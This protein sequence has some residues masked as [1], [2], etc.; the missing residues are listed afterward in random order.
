MRNA[1]VVRDWLS[2]AMP[3]NAQVLSKHLLAVST[4]LDK[5]AAF[6][7]PSVNVFGFWDWVGGRYSVCSAAGILPLSLH[8]GHAISTAFLAGA[9]DMDKHFFEAPLRGNLP[10]LLGLLGIWNSSFL[11]HPARAILPYAQALS[12]FPA[13]IQQLDMESNGK[14]VSVDGSVLGFDCGEIVFGEPG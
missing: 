8:F 10:V 1:H 5:A 4:A 7:I 12:R 14:R 2:A 13:H 3:G 9:H 6:G 11:G